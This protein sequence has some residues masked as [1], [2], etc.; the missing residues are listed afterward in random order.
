MLLFQ[1]QHLTQLSIELHVRTRRDLRPDPEY[2]PICAIFYH[3][4]TD[5][6]TV[7]GKNKITGILCVDGE[8]A[9]LIQRSLD[10]RVRSAASPARNDFQ[11]IRE[12]SVVADSVEN[13]SSDSRVTSESARDTSNKP[14]TLGNVKAC[15]IRI[16]GFIPY[17]AK[18]FYMH[19]KHS[20]LFI[21]LNH[22]RQ[23][24]IPNSVKSLLLSVCNSYESIAIIYCN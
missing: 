8:S 24:K 20:L 21:R 14:S 1:V 17:L 5:T 10:P 13:G 9:T 22:N 16:S 11:T 3:I 4:V 23:K 19:A 18:S 12:C 2:D 7:T 6:P 15:I